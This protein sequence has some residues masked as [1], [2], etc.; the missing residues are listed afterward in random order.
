LFFP[1]HDF[2]SRPR[3]LSLENRTDRRILPGIF[4]ANDAM[5]E[6]LGKRRPFLTAKR[7]LSNQTFRDIYRTL[8]ARAI[9]DP[10]DQLV[11]LR[12]A[13]KR[14]SRYEREISQASDFG[15]FKCR[16]PELLKPSLAA[17]RMIWCVRTILIARTAET[18]QLIVAPNK[19]A[20]EARSTAAKKLIAAR[21]RRKPTKALNELFHQFLLQEGVLQRWHR[22][23][24]AQ[25]FVDRFVAS[26]NDV[27]WKTL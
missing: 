3:R 11:A 5:H 2:E 22:E 24:S 26:G 20:N 16:F 13:F 14:C 25:H 4:I 19:L 17:K 1:P 23:E 9:T 21:R 12:T 18:G 6:F 27:A 8:E 15:W 7:L 10:L